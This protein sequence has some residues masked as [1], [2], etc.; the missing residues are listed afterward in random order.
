[1]KLSKDSHLKYS[2]CK[3]KVLIY[4]QRNMTEYWYLPISTTQPTSATYRVI[5]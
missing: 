5:Q 3:S 4:G 1:M 2:R